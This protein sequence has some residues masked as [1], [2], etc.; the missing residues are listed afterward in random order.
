MICDASKSILYNAMNE[1]TDNRELEHRIDILEE[2]MNTHEARI[3]S[4]LNAL[5]TDMKRFNTEASKRSDAQTKWMIGIIVAAVVIILGT[6]SL[7]TPI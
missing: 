3:D 6:F 2:R 4:T 7:L 5:R 1:T